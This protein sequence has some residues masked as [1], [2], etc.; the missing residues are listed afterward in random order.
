MEDR[1]SFL[2]DYGAVCDAMSIPD[3]IRA[4]YEVLSCLK[5]GTDRQVFLVRSRHSGAD[6]VLKLAPLSQLD[7]FAREHDT[8]LRLHDGAFPHPVACFA[9]GANACFLREH[10]PGRSLAECVEDD[11]PFS[12]GR[13][14]EIARKV[15]GI[16]QR[17]HEGTPPVI[18]RDIKPQN[19]ILSEDGSVH[20]VDLDS[21]EEFCPDK[22]TDTMVIGTATTAAP[23][24]FGYRR[25]DPRT[26]VYAIGKLMIYLLTGG[27]DALTL[28]GAAVSRPLRRIIERCV[29]FDPRGRYPS[30]KRLAEAL[31]ALGRRR[32]RLCV[33]AAGIALLLAL[34]TLAALHADA[35]AGFFQS[36]TVL[37]AE[38]GYA[39]ASPLIEKAVRL[40]LDRPQGRVYE[41]DLMS[42]TQ[43]NLCG[44]TAFADWYDLGTYGVDAQIRGVPCTDAALLRDTSDFARMPNLTSLSLCRLS[45]K[46]LNFLQGMTLTHLSLYGN[47][48]FDVSAIGD[49]KTLEALDISNNPVFDLEPLAACPALKE[50]DISAT[51]ITDLAPLKDMNLR[52]LD[53]F[54]MRP[55]ADLSVLREIKG[56]RQFCADDLSEDA[57]EAVSGM[58]DLT[59]LLL[60]SSGV[61][62]LRTFENLKKLI[63]LNLRGNELRDLDGVE[64]FERLD[65]LE[66]SW[67]HIESLEPLRGMKSLRSV[68]I[69]G[70]PL[71]DLAPLGALPA[72]RQVIAVEDQR[73]MLDALPNRAELSIT[74]D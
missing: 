13:A 29:E 34:G 11:E 58:T 55:D 53:L 39:F 68:W 21:V 14:A 63:S 40:Q 56:L 9:H 64:A 23:E 49:I 37:A 50:L 10:V 35:I 12:E 46:D 66:V 43:L 27:Y 15:C 61:R 20:L 26:D 8:L 70:N 65:L 72:L 48:I 16:V 18:H 60:F 71:T 73:A 31:G 25:C 62:S 5:P 36:A 33:T 1:L 38:P 69:S 4:E 47:Y 19:L 3:A 22:S 24:Q 41:S 67:N 17:L 59:N 45:L 54:A 6:F 2:A 44:E 57:V 52:A 7:R 74:Y 42:I 51:G 32:R 30:V 28:R